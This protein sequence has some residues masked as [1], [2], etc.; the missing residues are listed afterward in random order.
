[1]PRSLSTRRWKADRPLAVTKAFEAFAC[2]LFA[3]M[4]EVRTKRMF[5]GSSVY[6]GEVLFALADDDALWIK[7]DPQ[8]E[9]AF[10]A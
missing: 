6:C 10:V 2:E 1:M 7:V 3:G 5:G 8:S 9:P 4:S